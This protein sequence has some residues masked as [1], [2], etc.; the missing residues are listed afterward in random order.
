MQN[1]KAKELEHML[2]SAQSEDIPDIMSQIPPITFVEYLAYVSNKTGLRKAEIIARS[3]IP[4]TYAY[5]IFQGIRS[6]GRDHVLQLAFAMGLR[7]E[8]TDRLLKLA[9]HS[10]LYAKNKRD[11][12]LIYCLHRRMDLIHTDLYLD[13][14]HLE[15][16]SKLVY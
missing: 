13:D 9:N 12:I 16:L 3:Q 4:R 15:P 10:P 1:K 2:K 14:Y 11:A 6:P 8:A 5:Q 7:V